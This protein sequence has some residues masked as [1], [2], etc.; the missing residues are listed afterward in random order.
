[1][2]ISF[3]FQHSLWSCPY[4]YWKWYLS[5]LQICQCNCNTKGF[6]SCLSRVN[7][8]QF[9]FRTR[10]IPSIILLEVFGKFLANIV[11]I[12]ISAC[13]R[14]FCLDNSCHAICK[15]IQSVLSMQSMQ[16]F[17]IFYSEIKTETFFTLTITFLTILLQETN[18]T[19]LMRLVWSSSP[20]VN[21]WK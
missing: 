1:M 8:A 5:C 11:S 21:P 4:K 9:N 20:N 19:F 14:V 3:P 12:T 7:V 16:S 13:R 10:V 2:D 18:L 15:Y 17:R 6:I